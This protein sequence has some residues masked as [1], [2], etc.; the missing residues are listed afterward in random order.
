[1]GITL[2]SAPQKG[3]ESPDNRLRDAI[4]QAASVAHLNP[5]REIRGLLPGSEARPA[6]VFLPSWSKGRDVTVVSPLQ[7]ACVE[8][9]ATEP[10]YALDFARNR[11]LRQNF[12]ACR[13]VGVDLIPL[14]VE[15]L[16][17]WHQDAEA[18]IMRVARCMARESGG[19]E[20]VQIKHFFQKLGVLLQRGNAALFLSRRPNFP[21]P[22]LDGDL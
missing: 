10:G 15:T 17:G 14:P 21:A 9:A 3:R 22:D 7:V 12:E 19:Q 11:K 6:D 18:Q 13:A 2:F 5:S 4:F 20:S 8:R 16:G 1:M